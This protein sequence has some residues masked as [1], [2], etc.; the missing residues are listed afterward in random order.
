[1]TVLVEQLDLDAQSLKDLGYQLREQ[2]PDLAFVV[3]LGASM[4]SRCWRYPLGRPLL[5]PRA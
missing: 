2:Q 3:G 4:A 5:R 1:M